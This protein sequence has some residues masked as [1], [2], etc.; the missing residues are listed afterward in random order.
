MIGP[1]AVAIASS[2]GASTSAVRS[3][4]AI[5]MFFG[6]ISPSA[7]CADT[8]SSSA[9]TSDT[10]CSHAS[11]TPEGVEHRLQ[12]RGDRRLAEGAEQHPAQRD[13]QLRAGHHLRDVLHRLER[14]AG[15]G[16]VHRHRFDDRPAG[17]DQRELGGDEERAGR[18]Q[19]RPP[20]P[21][22]SHSVVIVRSP[23]TALAA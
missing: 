12:Q 3:G 21:S 16:T 9:M 11:G 13:A 15:P 2:G 10:G 5:A 1:I 14:R 20:G 4:P 19:A 8:T 22:S 18:Q 17:R 6:T 23:R 7:T